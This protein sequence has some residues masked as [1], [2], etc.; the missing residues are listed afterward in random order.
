MAKTGKQQN[1]EKVI[2]LLRREEELTKQELAHK[3]NLSMPTVLN[4][5]DVLM[6]GGILE[7][8]GVNESTGGRRAKTLCLKKNVM[9]GVGIHIARRSLGMV[10]T[11]LCGEVLAT[12]S[13]PLVYDDSVEWYR[14]LGISL[15]DF[16]SENKISGNRVLGVGISVPG[17]INE[18][19]NQLMRSHVFNMRN[20]SLDRFY[21]HILFPLVIANDANCGCFS[22]MDGGLNNF[23]YVALNESLGGAIVNHHELVLGDTWQAGEI[24][25]MILHPGGKQCYCGKRGCADAYLSADAL[26]EENE[27]AECFFAAVEAGQEEACIRWDA[28]LENLAIFLTNLRMIQNTKLILGGVIGDYMEPY[29]DRLCDKMIPYDLFARDIDYVIP[30]SKH[31]NSLAQGAAMMA[32]ERNLGRLLQN[33]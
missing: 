15:L 18:S 16:L 3:L 17:I 26:L 23:L 21:K 32:M 13:L 20:V 5:T 1:Q 4:I 28:Y 24:G 33:L 19:E 27:T 2:R 25:H 22:E 12:R 10:L 6:N 14:K 7:E 9:Y 8:S 29:M 11:D 30:C 31:T